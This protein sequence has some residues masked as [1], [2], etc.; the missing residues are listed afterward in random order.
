MIDEFNLKQD[1]VIWGFTRPP[2]NYLHVKIPPNILQNGLH[3]LFSL[4]LFSSPRPLSS[5]II[6]NLSFSHFII[7]HRFLKLISISYISVLFCLIFLI[8]F[9][10]KMSELGSTHLLFITKSMSTS[11]WYIFDMDI[12]IEPL[13]NSCSVRPY[14]GCR[15]SQNWL[16]SRQIFG[17]C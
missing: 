6:G 11:W 14:L 13:N 10:L 4:V 2:I 9:Y 3:T 5:L 16:G 12:G 8:S 1:V 17:C 7:A 15:T